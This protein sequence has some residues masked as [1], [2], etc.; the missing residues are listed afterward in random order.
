MFARLRRPKVVIEID[1]KWTYLRDYR[2]LEIR[3]RERT[4]LRRRRILIMQTIWRKHPTRSPR[5]HLLR[6]TS[7]AN[8]TN[9]CLITTVKMISNNNKTT[10]WKMLLRS[11]MPW[12]QALC[13]IRSLISRNR[14]D[15]WTILATVSLKVYP[16]IYWTSQSSP[17][18]LIQLST[19]VSRFLVANMEEVWVWVKQAEPVTSNVSASS[20]PNLSGIHVMETTCFK[21]QDRMFEVVKK[22]SMRMMRANSST[23]STITMREWSLNTRSDCSYFTTR[24]QWEMTNL[25]LMNW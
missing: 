18:P 23:S 8:L 5:H 9:S 1:L 19:R 16:R 4:D 24:M 2:K 25:S 15:S 6:I 17:A 20:L 11:V 22:K 14:L 7:K 10:R 12:I 21:L 3:N 13:S